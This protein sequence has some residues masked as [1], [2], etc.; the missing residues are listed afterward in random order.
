M[1]RKRG[2]TLIELLVVMAII[3]VLISL[4]LP[5]LNSARRKARE[6]KD[7][8]QL[9]QIHKAWFAWASDQ[10]G[11]LPTPG[12]VYRQQINGQF[13][14]GRGAERNDLN[15]TA[16]MHAVLVAE[17][18]YD[19]EILVSPT[20]QNA[21]VI[22]KDDYN[23]AVLNPNPTGIGPIF[24]DHS[25]AANL[26]SECNISYASTPILGKRQRQK[27]KDTG[28]SNFCI[29]GTRGPCLG[30]GPGQ[31]GA[32]PEEDLTYELLG[33][34][35]KWSGNLCFNDGHIN[36]VD[37][38]VPDELQSSGGLVF[39]CIFV[40]DQGNGMDGLDSV[41]GI[42]RSNQGSTNAA[43]IGVN[44]L[45]RESTPAASVTEETLFTFDRPCG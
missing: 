31:P 33:P 1:Q 36:R 2:F 40:N 17:N 21:N 5:A 10:K 22:V 25:M 37:T 15:T 24:W 32:V 19:T 44:L 23:Y 18:Y 11:R 30:W 6:T 34:D 7:R 14:Q 27:W 3:A 26:D 29:I 43:P 39:D 8:T 16:N 9:S 42:V 35:S 28:D 45:D 13:I 41:I 4:L 12:L 38:F 20:E